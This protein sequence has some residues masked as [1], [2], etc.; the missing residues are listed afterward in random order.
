MLAKWQAMVASQKATTGA[1]I[2]TKEGL[3]AVNQNQLLD[4]TGSD[5]LPLPDYADLTKFNGYGAYKFAKNPRNEGRYDMYNTG[6]SFYTMYAE[7]YGSEIKIGSAGYAQSYDD[8]SNENAYFLK[9]KIFGVYQSQYLEQYRENI[10]YPRIREV[11]K[12]EIGL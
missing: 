9:G 8:G 12:E 1:I 2:D 6:N 11:I 3:I 5:G 10:L 4:G 7:S